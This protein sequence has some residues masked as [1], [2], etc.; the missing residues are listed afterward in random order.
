VCY[1]G[2]AGIDAVATEKIRDKRN[3]TLTGWVGVYNISIIDCLS[4][5]T[6]SETVDTCV[7]GLSAGSVR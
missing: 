3:G 4:V 7:Y 1:G 6:E 2:T 5:I